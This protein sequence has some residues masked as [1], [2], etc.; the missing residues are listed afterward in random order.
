MKPCNQTKNWCTALGGYTLPKYAL[1]G[2]VSGVTYYCVD[3]PATRYIHVLITGGKNSREHWERWK[4]ADFPEIA[5]FIEKFKKSADFIAQAVIPSTHKVR[6]AQELREAAEK[7]EIHRAI[8]AARQES[9]E[10]RE[11]LRDAG[12]PTRKTT[13]QPMY[14]TTAYQIKGRDQRGFE[15]EEYCRE[16]NPAPM[17]PREGVEAQ[18]SRFDG[19]P[20]LQKDGMKT[21]FKDYRIKNAAKESRKGEKPLRANTGHVSIKRDGGAC[22]TIRDEEGK[23]AFMFERNPFK[24]KTNVIR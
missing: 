22:V 11:F 12:A 13:P 18:F 9:R 17:P 19:M 23:I 15:A 6:E 16:E 21:C 8:N 2:N 7:I 3:V 1:Y 20:E 14:A 24:N 4:T 5:H 10:R